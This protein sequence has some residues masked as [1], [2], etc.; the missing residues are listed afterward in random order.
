MS[1]THDDRIPPEA[2]PSEA[3][4]AD[5]K[6]EVIQQQIDK[7]RSD[8]GQTL[9]AIEQKLNPTALR[10][11][12]A[13]EIHVIED[14]VKEVFKQQFEE[15]KTTIKVELAEAKETVK[16]ELTDAYDN[17]KKAVR[18]ATIGKVETMA[19]RA[20]ETTIQARDSMIDTVWQ[21]PLP[22]ALAGVGLV[23][24]FMNRRS[25]GDSVRNGYYPDSDWQRPR[26]HDGGMAGAGNA[27]RGLEEA[28]GRATRGAQH[29]VS[30][31]VSSAGAAA[32]HISDAAAHAAHGAAEAVGGVAHQ[33]SEGAG[34][35]VH[36]AGEMGAQV[37]GQA[38]EQARRMEASLRS[39]LDSNPLALGAAALAAGALVGMA[40]PRTRGEDALMG[41][42][43]D[44][45]MGR[46][47][48]LAHEAVDAAK[49][50]AQHGMQEVTAAVEATTHR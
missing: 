29:K 19:R 1:T 50:L 36:D 5:A 18:A 38:R 45:L 2:K 13:V 47:R 11:M 34:H 35:L 23:W 7:T 20:N 26:S 30:D 37:A 40:F 8:L 15:A 31:L 4:P 21:N 9:T 43:R 12:A 27:L 3:Q 6:A 49:D 33:V 25:S 32:G 41:T 39:T 24:L 42:S 46:A 48:G 17:T 16:R 10:E 28:A 14:K 44:E 22:A